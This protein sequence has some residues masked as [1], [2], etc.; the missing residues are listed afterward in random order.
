MLTDPQVAARLQAYASAYARALPDA[1]ARQ[2]QAMRTL[3]G[4]VTRE[5][6]VLAYNDVFLTI[7]LIAIANLVWFLYYMMKRDRQRARDA[8][9][10]APAALSTPARA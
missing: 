3:S 4:I 1:A 9:S 6:N 10:A 2:T 8:L 5:A 7:G